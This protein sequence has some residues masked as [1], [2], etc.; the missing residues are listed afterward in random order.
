MATLEDTYRELDRVFKAALTLPYPHHLDRVFRLMERLGRPDQ[1]FPAVIVTGSKGKGSTSTLLASLLQSQTN[2]IG[3][4]TGPHLHTYRERIKINSQN[5]SPADFIKHFLEVQAAI[6]QGPA[7]DFISRF[8]IITAIALLYFRNK[9]VDLAVL[10]VGMGGRYDAVNVVEQVPLAVFTPIELE[11]IR[12]LGP[13]LNDIVFHKSG[14]MRKGSLAV[15]ARQAESV[16]VLLEQAAVETGT[17]LKKVSDYWVEDSSSLHLFQA[18]N[19]LRQ[20]FLVSGPDGASQQLLSSMAGI[21]Q[22]ENALTALAAYSLLEESGLTGQLDLDRIEHT[23]LPGRLEVINSR[24]LTLV[25]AA[26]TPNAI[27][28]LVQTLKLLKGEPVW[29]LG[30]LRDKLISEMLLRLPLAGAQVYLVDIDSHRNASSELMKSLLA[31]YQ[32]K[33]TEGLTLARAIEQARV[34]AAG[35]PGGYVCITGSLYLAAEARLLAGQVD[36]A[37]MAEAALIRRLEQG[38]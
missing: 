13:T 14:I 32:V 15:T 4:F 16:Q 31:P 6:K 26:H 27:M 37:T 5:I 18:G 23:Q 36:A 9:K 10:E 8:E 17:V 20:S 30:F 11:H 3:L 25:D 33:L 35:L 7:Q 38:F 24:P 19:T 1:A 21:F 2:N 34:T 29:V 28:K 12:N 22:V